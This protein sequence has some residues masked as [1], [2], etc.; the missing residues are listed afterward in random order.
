MVVDQLPARGTRRCFT[1]SRAG[2]AYLASRANHVCFVAGRHPG[3]VG[4][5]PS[6][7]QEHPSDPGQRP[8]Q[9]GTNQAIMSGLLRAGLGFSYGPGGTNVRVLWQSV[10]DIFFL[11]IAFQ[12]VSEG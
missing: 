2:L 8:R 11:V 12:L 1:L 3:A 5:L 9:Q 7:K 10:T 4:P 6:P